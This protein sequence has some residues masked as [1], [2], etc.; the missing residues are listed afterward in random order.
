MAMIVTKTRDP[1]LATKMISIITC[2]PI[3]CALARSLSCATTSLTNP[4]SL[5]SAAVG[6]QPSEPNMRL[7]LSLPIILSKCTLEQPS[8]GTPNLA[9]GVENVAFSEAIIQ[10]QRV[11]EVKHAPMAGPLATIIRGF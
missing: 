9:N 7:A 8:G 10:S 11:A 2:S 5:A 3:S 1:I 4:A 6:V